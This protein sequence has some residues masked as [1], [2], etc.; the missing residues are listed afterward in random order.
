M[1][2]GRPFVVVEA[3]QRGDGGP[4]RVG[5]TATKKIGNAVI[6]NRAKR[7]LRAAAAQL[8]PSLALPASDY[9]F[10]ARDG[11]AGAPWDSLL[12]DVRK[13]LIRLRT[14]LNGAAGG[15][16]TAS[17]AAKPDQDGTN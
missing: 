3:R 10:I 5:F 4:V 17:G 9:V 6:R 2:A 14:A 15:P 1:R 12:D 16:A 8:T 13:A 11:T 7:R